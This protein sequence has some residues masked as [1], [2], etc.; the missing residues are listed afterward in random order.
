MIHKDDDD[1]EGTDSC[2]MKTPTERDGE[3]DMST[4]RDREGLPSFSASL[5]EAEK[6]QHREI[7]SK[8]KKKKNNDKIL[9]LTSSFKA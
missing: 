6:Q 3:G 8:V 1:T 4:K 5:S 2:L 7:C 9:M